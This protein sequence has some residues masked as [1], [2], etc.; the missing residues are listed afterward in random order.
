MDREGEARRVAYVIADDHIDS[1]SRCRAVVS[2]AAEYGP[3]F[4]EDSVEVLC[5]AGGTD[6]ITVSDGKGFALKP[7]LT[8]RGL[9]W[10]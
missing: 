4:R 2:S 9:C 1:Q 6:S 3:P 8:V 10:A 5:T 7:K